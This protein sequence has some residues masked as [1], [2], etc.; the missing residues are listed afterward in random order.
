[1]GREV[2]K[3][4]TIGLLLTGGEPMLRPDFTR[5]YRGLA[6]MGFLLTLYTNATMVSKDIMEELKRHPPHRIGVTVYGASPE[7]YDKVTGDAN[8]YFKMLEGVQFLK[9]LPSDLTIRTTVVR[10]NLYD[11]EK[12]TQWANHLDKN[13]KYNVSRIVTKP[14][15]GGISEV[16]LCRLTPEQS[17][18]MQR[19]RNHQFIMEPLI[20][21]LRENPE[22]IHDRI[23]DRQED[24]M[25][26]PERRATLYG[27]D[28][29]MNSYTISWDGKLIGCQMLGDCWTYPFEDG[30]RQAW[31]EFPSKVMLPPLPQQCTSCSLQCTACPA[32]RLSETNSLNGFPEY[33]CRESKLAKEMEVELLKELQM[34]V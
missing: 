4:G 33:L 34:I 9:Q 26:R 20:R 3:A 23:T 2:Q 21:F 17:V 30:F 22:I 8:A 14:V 19:Q 7:T 29:G 5:I 11:L 28:A 13:V 24:M 15:R 16:E 12:I 6:D 18:E 10:D 27:C 32:T 1:M 31:E 25:S